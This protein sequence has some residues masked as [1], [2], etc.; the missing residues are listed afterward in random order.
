MAISQRTVPT[1]E[2]LNGAQAGQKFRLDQI[3]TIIGRNSDCDIV[4]EPMSV[5]RR[6]ASVE[7]RDGKFLLRDLSSTRGTYLNQ[8]RIGN[9]PV[10]LEHGATIQ[11]AEL[12]LRF[13][14]QILQIN[15]KE[16]DTQSTI[17]AT[18]EV[19]SDDG[20]S[21]FM[22]PLEKLRALQKISRQ[23]SSK[24]ELHAVLEHTLESLFDIFPLAERGFILLKNESGGDLVPQVIR[25]RSG[26]IGELSISKSV[27]NRVLSRGEAI[28][29]KDPNLDFPDQDS[30]TSGGIRSL[31]CVPLW[32]GDQEVIGVIQIDT[33][34]QRFG[35]DQDDLDLLAGVAGQ[36]AAAVQNARLHQV[37]MTQGELQREL[38]FARQVMQA[39]LPERPAS[40]AGYEFWEYYEPARHIGGDYY[41]Y[42]PLVDPQDTE[43][44][45]SSRLAVAVGDVVGKGLAAA[46]LTSKL[47]SEIRLFL[48]LESD[49]AQVVTR[50]NKHL[51]PRGQL[52]M[53]ITFLLIILDVETHRMTL[54]NAGHPAPLIRRGDGR[55]EEFGRGSSSI[56]L[57]IMPNCVYRSVET[58]LGEDDVVILYSDGVTDAMNSAHRRFDEAGRLVSTIRQAPG[59]PSEI[60][61]CIMREVRQHVGS[62]SQFDDITLICLGR[63]VGG[64]QSTMPGL[65]SSPEGLPNGRG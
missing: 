16:D 48:Q 12:L 28:L 21:S 59:G 54:V 36:I 27:L 46:L 18:I 60:G 62:Q 6:H 14:S 39:L 50:L 25:S 7:W 30:G 34:D 2:L 13:R 58:H 19:V 63:K 23:L 8:R 32:D 55:I 33:R 40:I 26:P 4:L 56:P 53:F 17:Y 64:I 22:K 29:G 47:S 9:D 24:L 31:M 42:I 5:S 37:L 38:Q 15:E 57:A 44:A 45:P 61:E 1:L 65:P 20:S 11:I 3:I 10:L 41:G 52:D 35:F 49:P 43:S 51:D